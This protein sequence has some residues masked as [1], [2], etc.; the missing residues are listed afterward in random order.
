MKITITITIVC[1]VT[2]WRQKIIIDSNIQETGGKV[3]SLGSK[4][5]LYLGLP[6]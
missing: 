5:I 6:G 2:N 3:F 4:P 1:Y